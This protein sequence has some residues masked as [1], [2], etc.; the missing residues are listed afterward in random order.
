MLYPRYLDLSLISHI[1]QPKWFF[2]FSSTCLSWM[3]MMIPFR[4][5][6]FLAEAQRKSIEIYDCE[7]IIT[8]L[9]YSLS[10]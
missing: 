4:Y 2:L 3:G 8:R 5:V 10:M 1:F 7:G 9:Y 6:I